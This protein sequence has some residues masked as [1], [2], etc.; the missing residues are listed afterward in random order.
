M[1]IDLDF[2][3]FNIHIGQLDNLA[4]EDNVM[5][6][7]ER[8]SEEFLVRLLGHK[9]A[10]DYLEN[11]QTTRKDLDQILVDRDKKISPIANYVF[12]K[13]ITSTHAIHQGIGV[14]VPNAENSARVNPVQKVVVAWNEMVDYICHVHPSIRAL[15]LDDYRYQ[16]Q[17][18]I[19]RGGCGC[20]SKPAFEKI[21]RL[22]I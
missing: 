5:L 1:I 12:C 4:V 11:Y 13:Y 2:F 7:T 8:Y 6:Y 18:D 20:G 3:R 21:N 14:V 22:G 10:K 17:V 15:G 19:C 16:N 9:L